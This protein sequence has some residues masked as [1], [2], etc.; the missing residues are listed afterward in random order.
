MSAKPTPG[1][2]RVQAFCQEFVVY[3]CDD[4]IVA[5]FPS[6]RCGME[7]AEANARAWVEG[8]EAMDRLERTRKVLFECGAGKRNPVTAI[9][10]IGKLIGEAKP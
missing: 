1:P 10:D 9:V 8:M 2:Y 6:V 7:Q 5:K 4:A 3:D